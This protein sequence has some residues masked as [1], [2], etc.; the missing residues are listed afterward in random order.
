MAM[1]YIVTGVGLQPVSSSASNLEVAARTAHK[2]SDQ[3][4][5][6]VRVFD[7]AGKEVPRE[8]LKAAWRAFARR[9]LG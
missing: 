4:V 1:T 5:E 3:G 2:M 9:G 7:E 6:E 8:E